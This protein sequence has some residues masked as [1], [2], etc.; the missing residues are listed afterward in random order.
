MAY[1]TQF[2][3]VQLS[4][5]QYQDHLEQQMR[6][7]LE[8]GA[9]LTFAY[10]EQDDQCGHDLPTPCPPSTP[11]LYQYTNSGCHPTHSIHEH[12]QGKTQTEHTQR[13]SRI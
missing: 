3:I 8:R 7:A 12:T 2:D 11:I 4:N 9:I 13:I 5:Q 10:P 6:L 1:W